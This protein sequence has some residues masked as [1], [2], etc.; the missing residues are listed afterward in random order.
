[1]IGGGYAIG[2]GIYDGS[3]PLGVLME[4]WLWSD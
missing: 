3:V 1:M 2:Q 4:Y